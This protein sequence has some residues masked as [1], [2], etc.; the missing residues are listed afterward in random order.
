MTQRR[1]AGSD[2][3][4][5]WDGVVAE[6]NELDEVRAWVVWGLGA[7]AETAAEPE[8]AERPGEPGTDV[9]WKMA[10][11]LDPEWAESEHRWVV[12]LEADEDD[13]DAWVLEDPS[14]SGYAPYLMAREDAGAA[15]GRLQGVLRNDVVKRRKP[16]RFDASR[17]E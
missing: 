15:P 3:L 13:V 4:R 11:Q 14:V 12:I 1:R 2:E 16:K 9:A 7:E 8:R 6:A 5:D 17:P 10:E